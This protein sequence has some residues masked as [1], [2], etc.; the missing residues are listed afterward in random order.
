MARAAFLVV[1][2]AMLLAARP[3]LADRAS[4]E[5][6]FQEGR[7]LLDAKKYDEARAKF[8]ASMDAEPSVGALLN[9][10]RCHELLG[11]V[12]T[13]WEKYREAAIL[14][15]KLGQ[16]D[17]EAGALELAAEL[18]PELSR[19]TIEITRRHDG[20]VLTRDGREIPGVALGSPIAIDPGIHR[21]EARAPGHRTWS[22]EIVVGDRADQLTLVVPELEPGEDEG[23]P[24]APEPEGDAG[25]P[26]FAL[27]GWSLL[28][29]GAVVLGIGT[30]L[31]VVAMTRTDDLERD[32]QLCGVDRLC[33]AEGL[34]E[35]DG[36][37]AMADAATALLVVGGAA[38]VTGGVLLLVAPASGQEVVLLP[39]P[40]GAVLR[41]SF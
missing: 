5:T 36:V 24:T 2:A 37:R 15:G 8:E 21:I 7:E 35:L 18:E 14:A 33:T 3:A 38:A 12:A 11:Q 28:G 29:G 26:A 19:L 16:R 40:G 25:M 9:L 23:L 6:L 30:A 17:R 34:D 27:A 20:L 1:L 13:A 22:R 41:G 10:A 32:D 4:A 39:T 31:G